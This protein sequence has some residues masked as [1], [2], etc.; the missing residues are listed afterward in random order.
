MRK[1]DTI[2]VSREEIFERRVREGNVVPGRVTSR[3]IRRS[4]KCL[5]T[6]AGRG[7]HIKSS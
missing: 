1:K 4:G 3:M 2:N 5:V 7:F 6:R